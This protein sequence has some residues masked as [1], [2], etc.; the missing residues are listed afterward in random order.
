MRLWRLFFFL[1]I[2]I[3][4]V[5]M[6]IPLLLVRVGQGPRVRAPLAVNQE[7]D[8][9]VSVYIDQEDKL[10]PMSLEEYLKGVV[11]AEMP[12]E[13]HPEALKAQAIVARTYA[14]ARM[15]V[16]GGPG[17]QAHPGA[18]ICT[19]PARGQA[20]LS[21]DELRRRWGAL[22]FA[23]YWA[24]IER[25]V[26][27]TRGLIVVYDHRPIDAVYHA[28][29]G[30]RTEDAA[31]VWGKGVPYLRGIEV[32]F[33]EAP[34]YE[35]LEVTFTPA[36]L[37]GRTGVRLGGDGWAS[38][39]QILERSPSGRVLKARLGS[40]LFTGAELRKLLGLKSTF[41]DWQVTGGRLVVRTRGY[42]HGVGMSQ[43]GADSLARAGS[44]FTEIIKRFYTGVETRPVFIE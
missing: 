5:V 35:G 8:L 23:A 1:F 32:P 43:Y 30:G 31:Y 37:A 33:E 34:R 15:R 36:E 20:W 7:G 13:F 14:V 26:A 19:D 17:C 10:V 22:R 44:D 41:F 12:A 39:A 27:D 2:F 42:G 29:S 28:A 38:Q 4:L 25:A 24:K 9:P 11:A 3:L 18:D 16:F 6:G 40:R 21:K